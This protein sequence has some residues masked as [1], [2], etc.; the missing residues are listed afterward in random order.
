[1]AEHHS[2]KYHHTITKKHQKLNYASPPLVLKT[3]AS[4]QR[5]P[6]LV[7]ASTKTE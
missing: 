6:R 2:K 4:P 7:W 1:M 3:A 5:L